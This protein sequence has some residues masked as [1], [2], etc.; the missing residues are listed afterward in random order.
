[1]IKAFQG[2]SVFKISREI[3]DYAREHRLNIVSVS[4]TGESYISA[5]AV[6]KVRL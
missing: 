4:I 5:I 3:E 6:F 2:D 1:M